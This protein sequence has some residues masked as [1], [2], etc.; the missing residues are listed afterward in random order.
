MSGPP[1]LA[2]LLW[3][4]ESLGEA[5]AAVAEA[6]GLAGR[7]S[8]VAG[9]Q[10]PGRSCGIGD[11]EDGAAEG[12]GLAGDEIE[13]DAVEV[14][15]AE[16]GRAL[17]RLGPAVVQLAE[18]VAGCLALLRGHGGRVT[19][20]TTDGRR[21]GLRGADVGTAL[22]SPTAAR[23]A[24]S[25]DA[26]LAEL[27]LSARR[28]RRAH[29]ALTA[30][31][32]AAA[33]GVTV[34][35]LAAG[36]GPACGRCS[37]LHLGP[38]AMAL[39]GGVAAA[40]AI[41]LLS[42]YLLGRGLLGGGLEGSWLLAWG[43]LIVS[44]PP[45]RAAELAAAAEAGQRGSLAWR[46]RLF[47]RVLSLAPGDLRGHGIGRFVGCVL[48]GEALE[49]SLVGGAPAALVTLLELAGAVAALA[50]GAAARPQLVL[51]A[52]GAAA[53]GLLFVSHARAHQACGECR[54]ELTA[55][56]V[57]AI[58]GHR[59][60][61]ARGTSEAEPR[62]DALL[63]VY[64]ALCRRLGR[65]EMLLRA[66][67][68]RGW[69]MA[70]LAALAPG[71]AAAGAGPGRLAAS[72][73][74]LLLG[75]AALGR[76]GSVLC[77]LAGARTAAREVR[78]LGAGGGLRPRHGGDPSAAELGVD[79]GRA[80]LP[81]A[82]RTG[83]AR[84]VAETV[85]L[86]EARDLVVELPGR[87]RPILAG[88][89]LEIRSGDRVLL[90]APSGAGKSTLAAVLSG[91][92]PAAGGLLLL[93]GL[94]QATLGRRAWRRRVVAVPQL[95]AN[96]VFADTLAF[97]LLAGRGWPPSASDLADADGLCRELGL[98]ALLDRLPAGLEQRV[99]E[100]GWELSDGER[101]RVCVAR[102]LLQDCELVILD[103]C[104]AALD[105]ESRLEVL[106]VAVRRANALMMIAHEERPESGA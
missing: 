23:H 101:S 96:H 65:S 54:G 55:E 76:L 64:H 47:G 92:R 51:L 49:R 4:E 68:P 41:V 69:R 34:H 94:D 81:G 16:L 95:H 39:L 99:G 32:L 52:M 43:L 15:W 40:Q 84:G 8:R 29:R 97:N 58:A 100:A 71:L 86:V 5:L 12:G 77:D 38:P 80:P 83:A 18:P 21:H 20:L 82:R 79:A 10:V 50:H 35:L 105:P 102:A 73:G 36:A 19:I 72:L 33:P 57:E 37:A 85:R 27:P 62:E 89:C 53:A 46:R 9:R 60:R 24:A 75:Q 7:R 70:G 88:A 93:G 106:G 59:T 31:R 1:A 78:L 67:L 17:P 48:A 26:L 11:P 63:A 104:L 87:L 3:P 56:L 14:C 6:A 61:L 28:R 91:E 30:A 42:W 45:A 103:E 66:A 22:R 74:G 2:G 98:G 13:I 44:L 90:D 25:V